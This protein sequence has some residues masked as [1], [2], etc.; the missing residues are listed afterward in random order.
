MRFDDNGNYLPIIFGNEFWILDEDLHPINDTVEVL[1]LDMTYEPISL[2]KWNLMVQ[3]DESFA[4]QR[5]RSYG[6]FSD[7]PE[8]VWSGRAR[9]R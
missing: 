4:M 1:K 6:N 2:L 5:V 3:L 9:G 8:Y 7:I